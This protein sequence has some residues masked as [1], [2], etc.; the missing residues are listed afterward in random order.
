[1]S[2]LIKNGII[3]AA[4]LTVACVIGC[5]KGSSDASTKAAPTAA[6]AKAFLDQANDQLGRLGIES[7]QAGWVAQNFITDDTEALD[8]RHSQLLADAGARF[9][10]EAT[11][12]DKIEVPADQRRELNLLKL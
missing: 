11:K 3:C 12:F 9:A 6:D 7:S 10:K 8:A 5:S 1:M 2:I 4:M